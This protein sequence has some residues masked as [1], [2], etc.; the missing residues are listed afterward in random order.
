[1]NLRRGKSPPRFSPLRGLT[2]P[3]LL[4]AQPLKPGSSQAGRKLPHGF[5][6]ANAIPD[7]CH[8]KQQNVIPNA[9]PHSHALATNVCFGIY[10]I[11]E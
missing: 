10:N 4:G 5:G 6:I 11:K 1:M 3:P 7:N 2:L 8:L 9:T